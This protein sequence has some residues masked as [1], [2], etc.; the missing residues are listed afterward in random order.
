M[1]EMLMK[2]NMIAVVAALLS[3]LAVA[4]ARQSTEHEFKRVGMVIGIKSDKI[5][6][7][8]ALHATSNPG[9][10]DLLKK[11]HMHNFSIFIHQLDDGRYYLFGYYEYSGDAYDDDM[12]KLAAEPRNLQWL[13]TTDPMQVPL[14]GEKSW[15][16]MKEV[17]HNP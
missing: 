5:G 4:T 15:A 6:A 7:Y 9:V 12:K 13:S 10:R 17:Y 14:S 2:K 16:A 11:Y 1:G 8:E 3:L